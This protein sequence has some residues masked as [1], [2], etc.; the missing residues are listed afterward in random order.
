M[1]RAE[2]YIAKGVVAGGVACAK[3]NTT[4]S[5]E[6]ERGRG[7]I[8]IKVLTEGKKRKNFFD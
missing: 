1:H 3:I 5:P 6:G 2:G 4:K 7:K 8:K